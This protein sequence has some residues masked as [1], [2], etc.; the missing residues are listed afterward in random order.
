MNGLHL[1][2]PFQKILYKS[3]INISIHILPLAYVNAVQAP[4]FFFHYFFF[5]FFNW[6]IANRRLTSHR[7]HFITGEP[8]AWLN[9]PQ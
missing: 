1:R 2:E 9:V 6:W 4:L 7:Q 5:F 8:N 3:T